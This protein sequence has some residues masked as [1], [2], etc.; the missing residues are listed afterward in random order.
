MPRWEVAVIADGEEEA[1]RV[2]RMPLED[3]ALEPGPAG[4]F[5]LGLQALASP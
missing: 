5:R 3:S 1:G 4:G 2:A